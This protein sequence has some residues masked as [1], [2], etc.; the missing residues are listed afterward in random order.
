MEDEVQ[1]VH[2]QY[3][4]TPKGIPYQWVYYCSVKLWLFTALCVVSRLQ[5][6]WMSEAD[7][8][9]S[10]EILKKLYI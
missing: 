3:V 2:I 4:G 9:L 5:P 8:I 10:L 6:W 7:Q 1:R